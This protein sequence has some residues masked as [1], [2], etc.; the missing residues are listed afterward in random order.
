MRRG[1]K[2][3]KQNTYRN[4]RGSSTNPKA[5]KNNVVQRRVKRR[6]TQANSGKVPKR[7]RQS[8]Y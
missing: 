1:Q 2:R 4:F 5:R 3:T 6:S 8:K 7:M